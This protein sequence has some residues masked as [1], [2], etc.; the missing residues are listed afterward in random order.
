MLDELF[1]QMITETA[2]TVALEVA[3]SMPQQ[4]KDDGFPKVMDVKQASEYLNIGTTKLY[5]LRTNGDIP[6]FDCGG[7]RFNKEQLD[8]WRLVSARM[9]TKSKPVRS[10]IKAG[11][12]KDKEVWKIA[13]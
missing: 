2:K 13:R 7:I 12:A 6:W 3:R 10:K 1:K 8:E 11:T 9:N 4:Q 5:E